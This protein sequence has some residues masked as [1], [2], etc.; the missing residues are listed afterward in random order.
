VSRSLPIEPAKPTRRLGNLIL[1]SG[2]VVATLD[3]LAAILFFVLDTGKNPVIVL[4]YIASGIFGKAA[5]TGDVSMAVWGLLLHYL[6]A[7]IFTILFFLLYVRIPFLQKNKWV[8]AV[9]YGIFVW[10]IMNL[11]VVPLSRVPASGFNLAKAL[12][13]AAILIVCIGLPLASIASKYYLRK[14][15]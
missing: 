10:I 12:R 13:G 6:I 1:F 7:F 4:N 14:Q 11:V 15:N 2:V 8:T 9:I 5:L 3:I